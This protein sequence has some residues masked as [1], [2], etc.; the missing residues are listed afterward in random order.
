VRSL[1]GRPMRWNVQENKELDRKRTTETGYERE[2]A[3][4]NFVAWWIEGMR[5]KSSGM[6]K[7]IIGKRFR[8]T[9]KND[10]SI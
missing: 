8:I 6:A 5:L 9:S 10:F 3:T 7:D 4:Q 2:F 1:K